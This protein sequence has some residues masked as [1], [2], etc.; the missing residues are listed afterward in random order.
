M[1]TTINE[2][3]KIYEFG[4]NLNHIYDDL[5]EIL[6]KHNIVL[7]N[8]VLYINN[9]HIGEIRISTHEEYLV[10]EMIYLND[11]KQKMGYGTIIY[12]SLLEV[13]LKN[14][15]QG[16]FSPAFDISSGQQ[17]STKATN[18]MQKLVK[19]LGGFI[20][21]PEIEVEDEL[22]EEFEEEGIPFFGPPYLDIY[23]TGDNI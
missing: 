16:I 4:N 11:N 17:R 9:E 10:M 7:K 15:Y 22:I 6:I 5:S 21:A 12:T 1:I 2:W 18:L 20:V 8:W 14:N 19:Q 3:K 13:A 23:L